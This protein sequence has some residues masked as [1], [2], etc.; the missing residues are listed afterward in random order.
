MQIGVLE[1]SRLAKPNQLVMVLCLGNL[2]SGTVDR[3]TRNS[4]GT[5][6]RTR[7]NVQTGVHCCGPLTVSVPLSPL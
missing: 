6:D 2:S 7:A 1:S 5:V 3:T 4:S